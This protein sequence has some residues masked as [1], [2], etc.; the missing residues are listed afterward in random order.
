VLLACKDSPSVLPFDTKCVTT[1]IFEFLS[2]SSVSI[3]DRRRVL[4]TSK[5]AGLLIDFWWRGVA[6]GIGVLCLRNICG[7]SKKIPAIILPLIPMQLEQ[8]N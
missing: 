5:A 6:D 8:R 7:W 4:A 1:L 2:S 3:S